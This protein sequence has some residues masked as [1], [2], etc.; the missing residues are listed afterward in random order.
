MHGMKA[1]NEDTSAG[2]TPS[3]SDHGSALAVDECRWKVEVNPLSKPTAVAALSM[4][5]AANTVSSWKRCQLRLLYKSRSQTLPPRAR[6]RHQSRASP[7][8]GK[9][10]RGPYSL[11]TPSPPPQPHRQKSNHRST[12]TTL[13]RRQIGDIPA[14]STTSQSLKGSQRLVLPLSTVDGARE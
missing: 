3:L 5:H 4:K 11:A 1:V 9:S 10:T 12:R 14:V 8:W 6:R 2:R 7:R 13:D